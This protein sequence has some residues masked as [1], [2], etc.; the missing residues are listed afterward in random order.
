MLSRQL[1]DHLLQVLALLALVL[2]HFRPL[3]AL[4]LGGLQVLAAGLQA[5]NRSATRAY[6]NNHPARLTVTIAFDEIRNRV[7]RSP[8]SLLRPALMSSPASYSFSARCSAALCLPI[9]SKHVFRFSSL[10]D[11]SRMT[12]FISSLGT[13]RA[14][15]SSSSSSL[16]IAWLN[17]CW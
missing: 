10:A 4:V 7:A 3:V 8:T 1:L 2:Q 13:D 5:E 11:S 14:F 12:V 9:S 15:E 6:A 16:S 17:G